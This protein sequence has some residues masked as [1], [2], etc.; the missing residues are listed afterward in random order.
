M[1]Y[2][3]GRPGGHSDRVV[4]YG[5]DR[6][7]AGYYAALVLGTLAVLVTLFVLIGT[8]GGQRSEHANNPSETKGTVG[9][10]TTERPD[11]APTQQQAPRQ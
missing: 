5:A 9:Q 4:G 7:S 6:H 11:K 8:I 2:D 1:T 10:A 3:P